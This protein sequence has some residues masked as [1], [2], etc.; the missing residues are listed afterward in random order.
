MV[1][2]ASKEDRD[3]YIKSDPAH[4]EFAAKLIAAAGGLDNVLVLDF[5][6]AA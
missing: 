4:H 6:Y 2:F 3:Y 1:E 5:E